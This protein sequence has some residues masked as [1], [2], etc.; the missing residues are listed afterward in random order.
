MRNFLYATEFLEP[1]ISSFTS[2]QALNFPATRVLDY[3]H[4]KR[5]HK[6][7]VTSTLQDI[8]FDFGSSVDIDGVF[9]NRVN[10]PQVQFFADDT[11]AMTGVTPS[12]SVFL[13]PF[14]GG[15]P[16]V[17]IDP[18]VNRRKCL[19]HFVGLTARYFR[20]RIPASQTTDDGQAAYSTG[21]ILFTNNL[22]LFAGGHQFPLSMGW[23]TPSQRTDFPDLGAEFILLGDARY[24]LGFRG[25]FAST[26]Q[27][28]DIQRMMKLSAGDAF[29]YAENLAPPEQGMLPAPTSDPSK[30]YL[31]RFTSDIRPSY[32][33]PEV[34]DA[35]LDLVEIL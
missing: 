19:F 24:E 7:T 2:E 12:A 17:P 35:S 32:L 26:L 30:V 10:Y 8:V 25:S 20:Y 3:M 34:F 15:N 22:I 14:A 21:A 13:Y 9:V 23:P 18:R 27:E 29:L 1:T 4:P 6:T 5:P 31:T 33:I 16:T 11:T 28:T